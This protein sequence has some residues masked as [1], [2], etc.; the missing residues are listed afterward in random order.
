MRI[1]VRQALHILTIASLSTL[2][3]AKAGAQDY[4]VSSTFINTTPAWI[5]GLIPG[6]PAEYDVDYYR[7]TYNTVDTQG[8]PIVAS[9]A[10]AIPKTNTCDVFPMGVYCHG[11]VLRQ[12]DVPSFGSSEAAIVRTLS[13]TGFIMVAPDYVGLGVNLGVHPYVHAESQATATIDLIFAAREFL[14]TIPEAD[15]GEVFVTGYSQ[16][17][18]AAMATLK[19]AQDNNLLDELG[20][21]AGAPCSGPY[22]MSG[23]QAETILSDE[24]Y[25]NPGYIVY[26]LVSYQTA[27]GN[28]YNSLSDVIQSPYDVQVA[29][30]FDGMQD[31]Y[32]MS[33]VNAILP[34]QLSELLVDTVLQNFTN[35]TNH[36]LWVALRDNDNYDW[37][38]QMPLRMFYCDGDEQVAYQNTTSAL[39]AM[40]ENG[41]EDVAVSNVLPGAT[42]GGCVL[43]ALVASYNFFSSLATPCGL[44]SSVNEATTQ[45]NKLGLWPNPA[46]ALVQVHTAGGK[47][48]LTIFDNTGRLVLQQNTFADVSELDLSKLSRGYYIATFQN[49]AGTKTAA[50][51]VE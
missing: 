12:T 8:E 24:P 5:L 17:G 20:I 25:S 50:L 9:G 14:E 46:T 43:P 7:L 33:T 16:G 6:L 51:V 28:I 2:F 35:N 18:H 34:A 4:L 3:A 41:A 15:N 22:H 11:T 29:P 30:Y 32:N 13:S 42:H 36:P 48:V 26:L 47:G 49:T 45:T 37:T 10:I 19:Y 38:P 44:I 1:H 21:V 39:A 31:T 40:Q 23:P 27:Y